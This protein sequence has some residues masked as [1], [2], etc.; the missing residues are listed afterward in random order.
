M[1]KIGKIAGVKADNKWHH[2]EFNILDMLKGHT[3]TFIVEE[4]VMANWDSTG[5]MKLEFG[6][7][8]KGACFYIDNFSIG[9]VN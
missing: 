7:N 8:P 1:E 6:N 9:A 2:T 4:I 5:F 3:N